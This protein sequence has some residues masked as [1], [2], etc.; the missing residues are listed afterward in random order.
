MML[1]VNLR[2]ITRSTSESNYPIKK[3]T[4]APT[5]V[6]WRDRQLLRDLISIGIHHVTQQGHFRK[7]PRCLEA[8]AARWNEK[9]RL[10]LQAV[11]RYSNFWFCC[12]ILYSV[13][14]K[15]FVL[16]RFQH[17]K[18]LMPVCRCVHFWHC[19]VS[20]MFSNYFSSTRLLLLM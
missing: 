11:W 15:E 6:T 19:L 13:T 2:W 3:R 10:Y 5:V 12:L 17:L 8:T 18:Q 1:S 9:P 16:W 14:R 7:L 20:R 4:S